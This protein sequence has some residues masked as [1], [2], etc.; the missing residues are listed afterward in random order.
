MKKAPLQS[1]KGGRPGL[2]NLP[3]TDHGR[4]FGRS[5]PFHGGKPCVFQ[6]GGDHARAAAALSVW[7]C[8]QAAT[9]EASEKKIQKAVSEKTC[10][11]V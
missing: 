10:I 2:L 3:T 7:M 8:V 11:T 9:N 4:L 5:E 1:Q 6:E